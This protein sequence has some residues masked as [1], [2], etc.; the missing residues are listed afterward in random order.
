MRKQL[1]DGKK[2]ANEIE[3]QTL[4]SLFLY[5]YSKLV[6]FYSISR[7]FYGHITLF[8]AKSTGFIASV[9]KIALNIDASH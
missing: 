2:F 3:K 6:V 5:K 1:R 7:V 4:K 8:G 9:G